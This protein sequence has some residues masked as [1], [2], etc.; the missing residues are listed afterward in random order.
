M[1]FI[2]WLLAMG[3][4][5]LL[6]CKINYINFITPLF[7]LT[8]GGTYLY[9]KKKLNNKKWIDGNLLKIKLF[10]LKITFLIAMLTLLSI[11]VNIYFLLDVI[12][13][14]LRA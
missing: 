1:I 7:F 5:E 8:M 2:A 9:Q 10:E 4:I 13:A 6:F 12:Y 11:S 14:V 3:S